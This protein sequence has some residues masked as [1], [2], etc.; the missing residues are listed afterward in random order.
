MEEVVDIPSFL[1][2]PFSKPLWWEGPYN[3]HEMDQDEMLYLRSIE[4]LHAQARF[5]YDRFASALLK[6]MTSERNRQKAM[7][8]D[9]TRTRESR[10]MLCDCEQFFSGNKSDQETDGHEMKYINCVVEDDFLALSQVLAI[11][12]TIPPM[13]PILVQNYV[14]YARRLREHDSSLMTFYDNAMWGILDLSMNEWK[15]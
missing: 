13:S 3:E 12:G 15:V 9:R 1:N 10:W 5:I 2:G 6:W 11:M 7:Y 4:G 8:L 14:D